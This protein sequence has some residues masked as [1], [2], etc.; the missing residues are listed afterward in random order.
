MDYWEVGSESAWGRQIKLSMSKK[1]LGAV[2]LEL[3]REI[4]DMRRERAEAKTIKSVSSNPQVGMGLSPTQNSSGS[5]ARPDPVALSDH[6]SGAKGQEQAGGSPVTGRTVGAR[7]EAGG[8]WRVTGFVENEEVESD[9]VGDDDESRRVK[10]A[11]FE[12]NGPK[13]SK[14]P[15]RAPSEG[16]YFDPVVVSNSLGE[17][18]SF[19][20][21]VLLLSLVRGSSPPAASLRTG[22]LHIA[23]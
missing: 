4:E 10:M 19:S 14:D 1:G 12:S 21:Q 8:N 3:Q 15:G 16:V 6:Q 9:H 7:V 22:A 11:V 2:V 17:V 18:S 20:V 13:D 23:M 5:G